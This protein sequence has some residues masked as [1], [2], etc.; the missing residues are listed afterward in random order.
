MLANSKLQ[1]YPQMQISE[2]DFKMFQFGNMGLVLPKKNKSSNI[3]EGI[4]RMRP[5]KEFARSS[6]ENCKFWFLSGVVV[7]LLL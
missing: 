2:Q 7:V 6:I 1:M 5:Q 3:I 4:L